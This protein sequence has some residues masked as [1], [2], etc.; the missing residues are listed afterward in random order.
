MPL[1]GPPRWMAWQ[2][3]MMRWFRRGEGTMVGEL[4]LLMVYMSLG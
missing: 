4:G 3:T 1:V 2:Q